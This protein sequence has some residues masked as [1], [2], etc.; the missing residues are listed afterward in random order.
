[1]RKTYDTAFKV[2]VAIEAIK[3]MMTLGELAQKYKI[4]PFQVSQW[5]KQLLEGA[6]GVFERPNKK[7]AQEQKSE[8]EH[9]RL[10]K[11]VGQLKVEND[12]LKKNTAN[13]T[14]ASR[15]S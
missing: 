9:D 10:P 4:H 2:K 13:I 14:G 8:E 5:K 7:R 11:T 12:F 3:E 1:M 6:D 15:D